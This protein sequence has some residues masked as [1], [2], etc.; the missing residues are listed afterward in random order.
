M[1]LPD[2][3]SAQYA[4][5]F[6]FVCSYVVDETAAEDIVADGLMSFWKNRECIQ[7]GAECSFLFTILRNKAL[8]YLRKER[9]HRMVSLSQDTPESQDLDL[10]ISSLN[11][12][13]PDKVISKEIKAIFRE[14]LEQMPER[15]RQIFL[16]HRDGNKTYEEI[17]AMYSMTEKG[18]EYHVSKALKMLRTTLKDY[19]PSFLFFY[20]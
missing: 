8:D 6:R 11:E 17:A 20:G 9:S 19:F 7:E 13:T 14:T 18:V 3:I 15:T 2:F 1:D 16:T 10:R 5:A 12:T 4:R